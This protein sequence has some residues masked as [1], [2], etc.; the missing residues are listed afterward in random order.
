MNEPVGGHELLKITRAAVAV[1]NVRIGRP[2]AADRMLEHRTN[3]DEQDG[4]I[5]GGTMETNNRCVNCGE[6]D[7]APAGRRDEPYLGLPGTLLVDLEVFRCPACGA[8][9][10]AIPRLEEL[11]AMLVVHVAT[12][13]GRLT[14][15]EIR[16]LRKAVGWAAAAD[17]A[18]AFGTAPSTVSRWEAETQHMDV[19]AE[20]LLRA[21][22]ARR[23]VFGPADFRLLEGL[24]ALPLMNDRERRPLRFQMTEEGWDI[25]P[26]GG[27][28]AE[29]LVRVR[30][31]RLSR[32]G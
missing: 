4:T 16:F 14:G 10:V 18:R 3:D 21:I 17:F 25:L 22:A 27:E 11:Q 19:R 8:E 9:E 32:A 1:G 12:Q 15:A 26:D 30:S 29:D 6:A 31:A 2:H 7:M 5:T 20:L 13:G 28:S 23:M 24:L